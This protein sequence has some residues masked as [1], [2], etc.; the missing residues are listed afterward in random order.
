MK[1]TLIQQ[2]IIKQVRVF[3]VHCSSGVE[4]IA[5]VICDRTH[6]VTVHYIHPFLPIISAMFG[7]V[8]ITA[9]I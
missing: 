1:V 2:G 7:E 9:Y 3:G 5:G 6:N 8:R 4:W